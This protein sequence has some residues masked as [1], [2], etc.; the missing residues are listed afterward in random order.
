MNDLFGHQPP[1]PA[2]ASLFGDAPDR[3]PDSPSDT[4]SY[5]PDPADIR[6]RLHDLLATARAAERMP[7]D[8]RKA[9]LWQIVFPQMAN[10]LPE[11]ERDQLRLEFAREIE[12]LM[13]A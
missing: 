8:P 6:R 11:E 5:L 7:W 2:Q 9:G 13:A 12:R 1:P 4:R 10:W 3:I